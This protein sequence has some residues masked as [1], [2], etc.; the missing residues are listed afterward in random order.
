MST[1]FHQVII[2]PIPVLFF[3]LSLPFVAESPL[4]LTSVT[5]P[6][7]VVGVSCAG[8]S[9]PKVDDSDSD[10]DGSGVGSGVGVGVNGSGVGFGVGVGGT[11]VGAGAGVGVGTSGVGGVGVGVGTGG[12]GGVGCGVG[13]GVIISLL[14]TPGCVSHAA[15]FAP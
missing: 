4:L 14:I 3:G 6:S 5:S 11:G 8:V 12:V 13:C 7:E 15:C 1:H 2:L 10:V 9:E